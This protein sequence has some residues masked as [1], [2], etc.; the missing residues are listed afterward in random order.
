MLL[1]YL[2]GDN[3]KFAEIQYNFFIFFH[4]GALKHINLTQW[5]IR[6]IAFL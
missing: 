1:V 4:L 5:L 2:D 6:V 3:I